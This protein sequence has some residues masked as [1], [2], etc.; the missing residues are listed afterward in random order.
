MSKPELF[1]DII[2]PFPV[3]HNF[4]YFVPREME[5]QVRPGQRVIVQFGSRK[6]Y[7][8][9]IRKIHTTN[10]GITDLKTIVSLLDAKAIVNEIQLLFWDWMSDY[11]MCSAGEVFKSALPSGLKMESES[12]VFPDNNFNPDN[13]TD[14]K[15]KLI[16]KTISENPGISLRRLS[17]IHHKANI[18]PD[19]RNLIDHNSAFLIEKVHEGKSI[20]TRTLIFLN[21]ELN[22]G[23][24][25]E[26]ALESLARALK[27]KQA[28]KEIAGLSCNDRAEI[29]GIKIPINE[30]VT[31]YGH[32]TL[33]SLINKN[34]IIREEELIAPIKWNNN[35]IKDPE[36]LSPAQQS[37]LYSIREKFTRR[38]VILLH[39]ITSSGKTEIYIHLI[40]EIIER[41]EQV[42]Y[43]LP[44][45][46]LTSQI[47]HRLYN[48]FGD[49]AG[50]YHSRF[51][52]SERVALYNRM[53]GRQAGEYK[54]ILG[55]RSAIFLPF[56][57]LGLI[58][59][60]EEHENTYKQFEPAPR[61]NARDSSI[62]LAS[63]YKAKVLLGTATPSVETYANCMTGKYEKV[64]LK[65][66][67][68]S[69]KLPEIIISDIIAARKRKTMQSVFTPVLIDAM[70]KTIKN[71]KQ[72]ILFQN[73]RGFSLFLECQDCGWIPKCKICDVSLIYHKFN[74][75]LV[76]HYCG[77]TRK[78]TEKCDHCGSSLMITRGFGTERV[79]DD[80]AL[81]FPGIKVAR[82]DLDSIKSRNSHDKLLDDFGKGEIN[83]L[84]GTQMISK[85]LDFE[86][87]SLV[88]ILDADQMLNYP[89]FRAYERSFQL[90]AQVSGRAGRKDER[91]KV[92]I[93]TTDPANPVI[94]FVKENDF[95]SMF[96]EQIRE[97][98]LFKYPPFVR[99]IKVSLRHKN[100]D[101]LVKGARYLSDEL[102]LTFGN[103]VYGPQSPLVGRISTYYIMDI[104][105]K[106]EKQSSFKKARV[107]LKNIIRE[108]E[109]NKWLGGMRIIL[110]VDPF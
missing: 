105:L 71:G 21:P 31:K 56:R 73:R 81:I 37:A 86:N 74:K 2:L 10:P 42:L 12:L 57:K 106:I 104:L 54:I 75:S 49:E 98:K 90:M 47:M 66:R 69:I 15:L 43:L 92:I 99:M 50:I 51:S 1:A 67:Y 89:D 53:S 101:M 70:D 79:E 76:C 23:P 45:I 108:A 48:V 3:D 44:E 91:G 33:K 39:G 38:D 107:L 14:N 24:A 60:D 58:I 9:I 46:A 97:R 93:Q 27:Q 52:D 22:S 61:Y 13:L 96:T 55:V 28:L 80:I 82:L 25:F 110:D 35:Q 64:V 65:E 88:G 68:G 16:Y 59:V 18:F 19:I 32:A 34:Y 8:G 29:T 5:G 102:K 17:K 85:G 40:K 95:E 41:G 72:V 30:I 26:K 63:F 36:T 11:Y 103:R 83:V 20:K 84:V 7:T 62:V 6:L 4:T 109:R 87:V 77:F 78:I 94:K 100:Y